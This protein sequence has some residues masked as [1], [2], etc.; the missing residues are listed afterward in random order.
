[1]TGIGSTIASAV[2]G[3]HH[4]S[5]LWQFFPFWGVIALPLKSLLYVRKV[6]VP[7]LTEKYGWE[8][9]TKHQLGVELLQWFVATIR[10]L[11]VQ[12][13]VWLVTDGAYAAKPFLSPLLELGVVVVSRLRKDACLYDL[14]WC[15]GNSSVQNLLGDIAFDRRSDSRGDHPF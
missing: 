3:E 12:S 11:G 15:E 2:S 13:K 7:K 8:F 6:D 9:R 14:P 10:S 4:R 5:L 1:M